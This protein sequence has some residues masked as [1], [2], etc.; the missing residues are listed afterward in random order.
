M[1]MQMTFKLLLRSIFDNLNIITLQMIIMMIV[2]GDE[3][4]KL[5]HL[6]PLTGKGQVLVGKGKFADAVRAQV[7][8]LQ[9]VR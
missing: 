3:D 5:A 6:G 9:L 8:R 2:V 7:G 4:F 1:H